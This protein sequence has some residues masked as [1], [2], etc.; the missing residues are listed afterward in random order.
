[1]CVPRATD[2]DLASKHRQKVNA[3][4]CQA[5]DRDLQSQRHEKVNASMCAPPTTDH[6]PAG[7]IPIR[8]NLLFSI[9]HA[10]PLLLELRIAVTFSFF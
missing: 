2:R 7:V 10:G 5:T 8:E 1:M 4:M 3:W 9:F 6:D